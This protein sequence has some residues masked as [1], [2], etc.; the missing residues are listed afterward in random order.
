MPAVATADAEP[1]ADQ[2]ERPRGLAGRVL[3][4]VEGHPGARLDAIVRELR[5][6][7]STVSG[8]AR[9]LVEGGWLVAAGAGRWSTYR[10]AR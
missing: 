4:F 7:S 1:A 5:A 8:A 2:D 6:E 3:A 10:A 9:S